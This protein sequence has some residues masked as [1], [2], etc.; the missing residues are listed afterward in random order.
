MN[1]KIKL[2]TFDNMEI[3]NIINKSE[4]QETTFKTVITNMT[5]G[6]HTNI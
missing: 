3:K 4:K 5:K 1:H 6:Y 2:N